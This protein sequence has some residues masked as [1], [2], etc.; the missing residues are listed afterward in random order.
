MILAVDAGNTNIV[1]AL[2][3]DGKVI[4]EYRYDTAKAEGMEYH[5]NNLKGLI[6]NHFI[7]GV[8]ISSVVPEINNHLET[9]CLQLTGL[10]P[11]FVS[12]AMITGLDIKYDNPQKLGA[13]L[14]CVAVG[15]VEKYGAPVIVI[16]IGTATTFSVVNENKE[17]LGGMIAPGPY[18]SMKSLSA[19]ASQLQETKLEIADKAIGTNTAECIRIGTLTA[20]CAMLDGMLDRVVD[21]LSAGKIKIVATGGF[22]Q[23]LTPMCRHRIICDNNL[24]FS[25]LYKLYELNKIE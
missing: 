21:E 11:E 19:T 1:A 13:D 24:I 7:E 3:N 14:I 18:T 23:K 9:A 4:N 10:I 17:Y 25:G 5:K 15:A 6:H 8:I 16:D 20:H 12:S 22:A 2:M